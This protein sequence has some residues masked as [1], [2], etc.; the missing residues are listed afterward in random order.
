VVIIDFE[1]SEMNADF[2]TLNAEITEVKSLLGSLVPFSLR[3]DFSALKDV[4][5]MVM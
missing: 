4:E 2:D 5:Y 1:S 3:R